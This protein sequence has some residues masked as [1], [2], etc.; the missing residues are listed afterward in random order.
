MSFQS[1]ITLHPNDSPADMQIRKDIPFWQ[2]VDEHYRILQAQAIEAATVTAIEKTNQKWEATH[3]ESLGQLKQVIRSLEEAIPLAYREMEEALA[4]MA[5]T[6]TK[7]LMANLPIDAERMRAV[8]N[9]AI[10]E[11]EKDTSLNIRLHPDD[12]ALLAE[13]SKGKPDK[14]FERSEKIRFVTDET[15]TRGGCYIKTPFGDFDATMESKWARVLA[16][17]NKKPPIPRTSLHVPE[18][19]ETM[20]EGGKS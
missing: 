5:C 3:R 18:N 19:I 17:F 13:Q 8:V 1:H 11:L 12:L 2:S 9:E 7:K 10:G 15:L 20:D 16:A 14:L 6:L 4:H